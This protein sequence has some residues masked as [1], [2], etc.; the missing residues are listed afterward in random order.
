MEKKTTRGR[1][2]ATTKEEKTKAKPGDK[3]IGNNFWKQR[4]KHGRDKI[5]SDASVMRLAIDEYFEMVS[6]RTIKR[7]ELM[8]SGEMAGKQFDLEILDYPTK[9]ELALHLHFSSWDALANYKGYGKDFLEVITYAESVLFNWKLK[10]AAAGVYNA[11]IVSR[12][13]GLV[14]KKEV[15]HDIKMSPEE[16]S[17]RIATLM[18]K[19]NEFNG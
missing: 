12:D 13:L 6:N 17:E 19:M 11:N 14:E 15:D 8:K 10:G 9:P 16:R 3:R 18:A 2:K 1:S 4:S 7:P 5:I